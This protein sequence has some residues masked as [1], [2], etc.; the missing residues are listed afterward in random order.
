MRALGAWFGRGNNP[1]G[2]LLVLLNSGEA[3]ESFALPVSAPG[4]PWICRFDTAREPTAGVH[5]AHGAYAA[6]GVTDGKAAIVT[7]PYALV[8]RSVV[9]LEC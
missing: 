9:L 2:R 5:G 4:S 3:D 8:A 7:S 1:V 6:H